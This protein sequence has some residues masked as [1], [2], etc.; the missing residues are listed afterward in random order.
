LKVRSIGGNWASKTHGKEPRTTS[1]ERE[2]L[3]KP[4]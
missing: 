1:D 4:Y 3:S 2:R